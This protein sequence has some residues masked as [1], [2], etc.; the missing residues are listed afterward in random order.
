M[1]W[2]SSSSNKAQ[3]STRSNDEDDEEYEKAYRRSFSLSTDYFKN[4]CY[5]VGGTG[6]GKT[7]FLLLLIGA[8]SKEEVLSKEPC[9]I[10]VIDPHGHAS[11][12]GARMLMKKREKEK[13][14]VFDP[15]H[16]SFA[17]NPL[18]ISGSFKELTN[19]KRLQK[20]QN[21]VGQLVSILVD[22]LGTDEAK[23]P[24]M[25]WI[26]RGCLYF[27]YMLGNDI[28]FLDLY[29]LLIYMMEL[30]RSNRQEVI[31]KLFEK[32]KV[33]EEITRKTI[34]AISN[35][36][37]EAYTVVLNRI[38]N[39]TIPP[40]SITTRT[41]CSRK[42][43]IPFDKIMDTP[44]MVTFFRLSKTDLPP[45]FREV[46]TN[47]LLLNIWFRILERNG[48]RN[49]VYL[50]VDEFQTVQ[51]LEALESMV[52]EGRKFGLS[53]VMANQTISQIKRKPLLDSLIG[54][55]SLIGTYTTGPSDAKMLSELF[56]R[57]H[58]E[59]IFRLSRGQ[60]MMRL[61]PA[62]GSMP[63]T[64]IHTFPKAQIPPPEE[65]PK[66]EDVIHY[67]ERDLE[68]LYGGALE[69]RRPIYD[70][71]KRD[72]MLELGECPLD[73][74]QWEILSHL[75]TYEKIS[76]SSVEPSGCVNTASHIQQELRIMHGWRDHEIS[77]AFLYLEDTNQIRRVPAYGKVNRGMDDPRP[78][79]VSDLSR[80][81]D[82]LYE[83]TEDA[84]EKYFDALKPASPRAGNI[85]HLAAIQKRREECW[86][87]MEFVI[88][89]DGEHSDKRPDLLILRPE[90]EEPSNQDR[91]GWKR[92]SELLKPYMAEEIETHPQRHKD[93]V[94]HNYEKNYANYHKTKAGMVRMIRFDVLMQE[95]VQ[96]VKEILRDKDTNSYTV[97][98]LDLGFSKDALL[99]R[100]KEE[101]SLDATKLGVQEQDESAN[102][103]I[104]KKARELKDMKYQDNAIQ[105]I[106][107]REFGQERIAEIR[108]AIGLFS[109]SSDIMVKVGQSSTT[110]QATIDHRDADL[111]E[112]SDQ[113]E[114]AESTL[115]DTSF[116]LKKF[117][118]AGIIRPDDDIF[119]LELDQ[120]GKALAK[121]TRQVRRYVSKIKDEG[122]LIK[123]S[124]RN[125]RLTEKGREIIQCFSDIAP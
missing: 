68:N 24:R 116:I 79:V 87:N 20:I 51:K 50:F 74:I 54:N 109:S 103:S 62:I 105:S 122:L 123:V 29:Q 82:F 104:Q 100:L 111:S 124:R 40:G 102:E 10:I 57:E 119:T 101:E 27:L 86:K 28:T 65:I 17:M 90:Q 70:D 61:R 106:L 96:P 15:N 52:S 67:M 107:L 108:K 22:V 121:S 88:V 25:L 31:A 97:A 95:Y 94:L 83:L 76:L 49:H 59:T 32:V 35:Y 77:Y 43:T 12:D 91:R 2:L 3:V 45:D 92:E 63:R 98:F 80:S 58:Y 5:V 71:E 84:R 11:L 19:E 75:K 125:Y 115:P 110:Q 42:T 36:N 69:A 66:E 81:M 16:T 21:Q 64:E 8:L 117:V 33:D 114:S 120:A 55:C 73:T 14:M 38:S 72:V 78:N 118:E 113:D 99:K 6:Q 18:E 4:H 41:F 9:S 93:R 34:E 89:D 112:Q 39:F 60:M 46:F 30:T 13:V 53:L 26:F 23:S 37:A 1:K 7:N 47:T 85:V 48:T 56:G 44:G